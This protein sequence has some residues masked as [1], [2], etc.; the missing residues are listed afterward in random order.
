M[1]TAT[2]PSGQ[3]LIVLT[4]DEYRALTYDAADIAM[5]MAAR[6]ADDGSPRLSGD[7]MKA[8]IAGT[9]HPLTAWRQAAGLTQVVLAERA[10]I[11]TATI[12]EIETGKTD[13][14]V[15]T[16]KSIAGVLGV[17]VDDLLP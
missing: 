14:R 3:K 17:D 2:T 7:A 16:M 4:E 15:S 10:N 8:I 9:L 13:P 12:N 5:A 1:N 11:R 6:A